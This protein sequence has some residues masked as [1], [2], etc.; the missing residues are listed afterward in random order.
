MGGKQYLM[1]SQDGFVVPLKPGKLQGG[2]AGGRQGITLNSNPTIYI[3]SR[4]DQAQ[5]VG[6]VREGVQA[7]N[8]GLLEQLRAQGAIA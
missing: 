2:A 3:D 8:Q 4:T 7:G 1:P 6:L 5:V